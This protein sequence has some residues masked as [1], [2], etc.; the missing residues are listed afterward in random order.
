[1][2]HHPATATPATATDGSHILGL[3]FLVLLG[4]VWAIHPLAAAA[5][6]LAS[7]LYYFSL[8]PP[9]AAGMLL[10][11]GAMLALLYALPPGLVWRL[12]AAVFA[13]AG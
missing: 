10:M 2:L 9:L 6:A 4:L 11:A 8:S 1:M 13:I 12:S 3:G 5:L 7:L